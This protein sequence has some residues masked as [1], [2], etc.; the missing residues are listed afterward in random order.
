MLFKCEMWWVDGEFLP[1]NIYLASCGY[2]TLDQFVSEQNRIESDY[3]LGILSTFTSAKQCQDE[4]N[5]VGENPN[6]ATYF[7]EN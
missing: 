1:S 6:F 4:F 7:G 2:E 3:D 5:C